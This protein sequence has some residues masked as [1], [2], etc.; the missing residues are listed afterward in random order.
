VKERGFEP[1][2]W[3]DPMESGVGQQ[4]SI[5]WGALERRPLGVRVQTVLPKVPN[6]TKQ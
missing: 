5:L 1:F 6:P 4:H 2:N 3:S